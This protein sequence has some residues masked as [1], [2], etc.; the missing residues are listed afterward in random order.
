MPLAVLDLRVKED[1][2]V[3]PDR[4]D[5][6]ERGEREDVTESKVHRVSEGNLVPRV[7]RDRLDLL[8]QLDSL[9]R[10]DSLESLERLGSGERQEKEVGNDKD[11]LDETPPKCLMKFNAHFL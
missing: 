10:G 5:L 3:P 1:N 9:E 2:Q 4:L 8:D 7:H 11:G 6:L